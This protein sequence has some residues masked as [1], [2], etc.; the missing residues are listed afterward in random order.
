ME[1]LLKLLNKKTFTENDYLQIV[2]YKN[3]EAIVNQKQFIKFSHYVLAKLN[4][5]FFALERLLLI[6]HE[7]CTIKTQDVVILKLLTQLYA[8]AN[9]LKQAYEYYN[10]L[11]N[12]PNVHYTHILEMQHLMAV[13]LMEI[14]QINTAL[15]V[16]ELIVNN[17]NFENMPVSFCTDVLINCYALHLL[18]NKSFKPKSFTSTPLKNLQDL[19]QENY[20]KFLTYSNDSQLQTFLNKYKTNM[21][22]KLLPAKILKNVYLNYPILRH[23][24]STNATDFALNTIISYIKQST[25]V[26]IKIQ[27]LV[28]IL[29][30]LREININTY[31]KMSN[32]LL[33]NTINLQQLESKIFANHI[34]LVTDTIALQSKLIKTELDSY[35]DQLTNVL[36]RTAFEKETILKSDY[37]ALVFFDLNN[38]KII[39]DTMGH[40]A[41]DEYLI[42]F[43][44]FLKVITNNSVKVYRLGGDEFILIAK[45]HTPEQVKTLMDN[46]LI[47]S[48][49]PITVLG[50]KITLSFAAGV[51]LFPTHSR[52]I[53][54]LV[55][56]ADQAMYKNKQTKDSKINSYFYA[57]PNK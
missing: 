33:Y 9:N 42:S 7:Q 29:P 6:A 17:T 5:N 30:I 25:D 54:K 40:N 44:S 37:G 21:Q 23:M 8:K 12:L 51:S 20:N 3:V 24:L 19:L 26:H 56:L 18:L 4:I 55:T 47:K 57:E 1:T 39:N 35:Y 10:V 27:I 36:N 15:T 46:L 14:F 43:A 52:N 32:E 53:K 11:H 38:L 49:N 48:K 28:F 22:N 45:N 34:Q 50:K 41:G 2:T 16:C 31:I 13:K